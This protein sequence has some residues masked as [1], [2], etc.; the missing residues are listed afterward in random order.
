MLELIV[1]DE[2]RLHVVKHQGLILCK[3]LEVLHESILDLT[4][5]IKLIKHAIVILLWLIC[6][7]LNLFYFMIIQSRHTTE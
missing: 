3:R 1:D 2:L 6:L 7:L 5:S 4:G